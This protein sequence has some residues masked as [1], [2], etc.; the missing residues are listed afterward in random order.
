MPRM[1]QC[2]DMS[3]NWTEI[4]QPAAPVAELNPGVEWSAEFASRGPRPDAFRE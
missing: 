4:P 1:P 3:Q 2:L